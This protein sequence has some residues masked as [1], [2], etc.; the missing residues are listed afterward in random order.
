MM[1][2]ILV[3][4]LMPT[5]DFPQ[6]TL[7]S[8]KSIINNSSDTIYYEILMALDFDDIENI[9]NI[10]QMYELFNKTKCGSI[11]ILITERYHYYGLHKYYN[12]LAK[13]SKGKLLLLWNNDTI[14]LETN[15]FGKKTY[16]DETL[17]QDYNNLEPYVALLYPI[18]VYPEENTRGGPPHLSN[19]GFPIIIRDIYE[20]V[21]YYSISPLNDAY[22]TNIGNFKIDNYSTIKISRFM[23]GHHSPSEGGITQQE[24]FHK[25]SKIHYS[26][27]IQQ[28]TLHDRGVVEEYLRRIINEK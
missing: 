23:I 3:S 19:C 27:E 4:F 22:L 2:E 13:M 21:G 25:A 12:Q 10:P 17:Q 8:L 28:R 18:E 5:R 20:L 6:E 14:C 9:N 11:Q 7:N 16:W 15:I 1:D 24:T 26:D